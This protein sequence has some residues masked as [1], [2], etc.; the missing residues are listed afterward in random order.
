PGVTFVFAEDEYPGRCH[1]AHD[2]IEDSHLIGRGDVAAPRE[3]LDQV[4][5]VR[6][7][8]HPSLD[9]IVSTDICLCIEIM[10]CLVEQLPKA[11]FVEYCIHV[12]ARGD[13][14]ECERRKR[15]AK[16]RISAGRTDFGA[17]VLQK[18]RSDG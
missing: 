9:R 7:R 4:G 5:G 14:A 2:C 15:A 16:Y 17:K 18:L 8:V 11:A 3:K 13:D 10:Q 12:V 6:R 1:L